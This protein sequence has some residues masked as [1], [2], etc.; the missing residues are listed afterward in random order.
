MKKISVRI[1]AENFEINKAVG[2]G[3]ALSALL[4]NLTIA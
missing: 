1:T 4:F 2:E 3:D